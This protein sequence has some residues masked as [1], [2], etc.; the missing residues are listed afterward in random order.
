M[1]FVCCSRLTICILVNTQSGMFPQVQANG[2]FLTETMRIMECFGKATSRFLKK[3]DLHLSY[4]KKYFQETTKLAAELKDLYNT[5]ASTPTFIF[6]PFE[7]DG[8]PHH[9]F[10]TK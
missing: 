10:P 6:D 1:H 3:R 7:G 8:A 2:L 4:T 5:L 9:I